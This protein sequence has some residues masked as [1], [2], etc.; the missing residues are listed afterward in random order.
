MNLFLTGPPRSGKTTVIKRTLDRLE[1]GGY[2]AGGIYC[3]ELRLGGER[4]GFE[5]VDLM[6]GES[7]IMAHVDRAD[8]PQVSKYGV[9]VAGIDEVCSVAFPRALE[10]ADCLIVDE[11]APMECFSEEF[12]KQVR[13]ALNSDLPLLA[14]VHYRST[15]GF[16]GEVKDRDDAEMFEVIPENRDSLPDV[17]TDRILSAL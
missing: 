8:G 7:K 11:I 3:P 13:R 14:A 9:D 12:V 10:G 6:T 16:I 2:Q 4:V 1:D 15:S 17:L 5:I